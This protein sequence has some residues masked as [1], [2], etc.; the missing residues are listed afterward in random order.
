MKLTVIIAL[1]AA[2]APQVNTPLDSDHNLP[3]AGDRLTLT[4]LTAPI[5]DTDSTRTLDL[6]AA[7]G[8]KEIN[9]RYAVTDDTLL[10]ELTGSEVKIYNATDGSLTLLEERKPGQRIKAVNPE[11][12]LALP[13]VAGVGEWGHFITFG[14]LGTL[15]E[16]QESGR[17]E[18]RVSERPHTIVTPEGDTLRNVIH[19]QYRK[20][21][22]MSAWLTAPPYPTVSDTLMI[23]ADSIERFLETDTIIHRRTVD[24]WY[25]DG[26]RYPIA[27]QTV[28]RIYYRGILTDSRHRTLYYSP[29][30]Q[31]NEITDDAHNQAIRDKRR[32]GNFA[33]APPHGSHRTVSGDN[34]GID[35][36]DTADNSGIDSTVDDG[37]TIV[38]VWPTMVDDKT[39]VTLQLPAPSKV[40]VRLSNRAGAEMWTETRELATGTHSIDCPTAQLTAGP[41]ILAVDTGNVI[42]TRILIKR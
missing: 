36:H 7:K 15:G 41:Y 37:E 3:R 8:Q 38:E 31:E 29:F 2:I 11:R 20:T 14:R 13:A 33:T 4:E 16:I 39:T 5:Y 40:T 26:Y 42:D 18:S 27:E 35:N 19:R 23:P 30:I 24:S 10:M 9:R 32:M 12:T 21:G 28:D 1:G 25:L 34:R 17:T 22:A 6:S